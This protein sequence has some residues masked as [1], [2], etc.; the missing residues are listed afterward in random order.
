MSAKAKS[1]RT[2]VSL[3][4]P[5]VY[6]RT[7]HFLVLI[8]TANKVAVNSYTQAGDIDFFV[9]IVPVANRIY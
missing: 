9:N 5:K 6:E 7:L 8:Q 1:Q 4:S 3:E 2:V